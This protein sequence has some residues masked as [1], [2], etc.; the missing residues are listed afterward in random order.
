M[1]AIPERRVIAGVVVGVA[2]EDVERH[3][4]EEL[5]QRLHR[6]GETCPD[7]VGQVLVGRVRRQAFVE[8]QE[9]QSRDHGAACPARL[10]RLPV[11]TPDQ[12]DILVHRPRQLDPGHVQTS[13]GGETH[14]DEFG[15]DHAVRV[16]GRGEFDDLAAFAAPNKALRP[17]S[18]YRR[19]ALQRLRQIRAQRQ[20]PVDQMG[21]VCSVSDTELPRSESAGR[22]WA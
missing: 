13:D 11:E 2:D 21:R 8:P 6:G 5:P 4:R 12:K 7:D 9:R 14:G 22:G 1:V 10:R 15:L 18:S 19:A 16:R 17:R 20:A 3:A